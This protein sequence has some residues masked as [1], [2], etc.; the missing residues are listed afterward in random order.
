MGLQKGKNLNKQNKRGGK[1][2]KNRQDGFVL[3]VNNWNYC[4]MFG[5][6]VGTC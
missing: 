2:P 3:T 6:Y 4:R 5:I 1:K